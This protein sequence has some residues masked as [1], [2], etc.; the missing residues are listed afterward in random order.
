MIG[1][2]DMPCIVEAVEGEV[3]V[4]G[5]AGVVMSLTPGAAMATAQ[6][7]VQA[8]ASAEDFERSTNRD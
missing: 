2:S 6:R 1:V 7:L 5:P 4:S 8:A 3:T